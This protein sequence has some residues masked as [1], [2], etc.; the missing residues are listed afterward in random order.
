MCSPWL[1]REM[2]P[3]TLDWSSAKRRGAQNPRLVAT[4]VCCFGSLAAWSGI[5]LLLDASFVDFG[6]ALVDFG[7]ENMTAPHL[8]KL[9]SLA[10]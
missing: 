6:V 10:A 4:D 5:L 1:L 7:V 3:K 8:L 2:K 9:V